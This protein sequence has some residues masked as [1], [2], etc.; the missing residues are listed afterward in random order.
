M[1]IVSNDFS[2]DH[3]PQFLL[4]ILSQ[5]CKILNEVL[6]EISPKMVS[7]PRDLRKELQSGVKTQ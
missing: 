1:R 6:Y 7:F 3:L 2:P 5:G 4:D